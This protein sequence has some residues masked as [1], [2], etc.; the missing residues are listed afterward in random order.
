MI[1]GIVITLGDKDYVVPPLNLGTLEIMQERL[2]QFRGGA[3]KESIA[4]VLDA[5]FAALK[6]N[7]PDITREQ[8]AEIVGLENMIELMQAI[9]DISGMRRKELETQGEPQPGSL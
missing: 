9:M 5:S 6:R 3:D 8:V 2:E 1:K 7:Y 4:T